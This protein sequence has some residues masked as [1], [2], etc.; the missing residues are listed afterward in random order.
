MKSFVFS[1]KAALLMLVCFGMSG[2]ASAEDYLNGQLIVTP[3]PQPT[4]R[5]SSRYGTEGTT[6]GYV[7]YRF[8]INN[9][10]SQQRRV[11]F[12]FGGGRSGYGGGVALSNA[13]TTVVVEP[14]S[15]TTAT[16]LQPPV[17]FSYFSSALEIRIDNGQTMTMS[18][19]STQHV[20]QR[21]YSSSSSVC[22]ILVSNKITANQRELLTRGTLEEDNSAETPEASGGM[23]MGMMVVPGRSPVET[24]NIWQSEI[25]TDQW[26]DQWLGYTRFDCVVLNNDD[27]QVLKSDAFR[28]LQRYVEMGGMLVV[29][30]ARSSP[31]PNWPKHWVDA[32][33][34]LP[35]GMTRYRALQG[36]AYV[37][38]SGN[39]EESGIKRLREVITSVAVRFDGI[40][41]YADNTAESFEHNVPLDISYVIPVRSLVVLV[42]FFALLIGPVNMVTLGFF[43]RRVWLIWTIPLTSVVA[44]CLVLGLVVFSEGI[45]R[46]TSVKSVTILDQRRR[47]AMT[48]GIVG[49]Y[50]TFAPPGGLTFSNTTEVTP[51]IGNMDGLSLGL[52]TSG[53]QHLTQNWIRPRIPAFF[54]VRKAEASSVRLTFD[55][56]AEPPTVTNGLGVKITDLKVVSPDGKTYTVDLLEAG[57]KVNLKPTSDPTVNTEH[58]LFEV[59][60]TF[61]T[62]LNRN[63]LPAPGRGT[64]TANIEGV[65]PFLEPGIDNMKSFTQA[66]TI[67][68][69]FSGE[70]MPEQ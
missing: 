20:S 30:D 53:S 5:T 38:P 46:V 40:M 69:I 15:E 44:S 3:L 14:K 6:H 8:H 35:A 24:H 32:A 18:Y 2:L 13:S 19:A 70:G 50:R 21:H 60:A 29:L 61:D 47:E 7:E 42:V 66:N 28:A 22:N 48:S 49:Y 36:N 34:S 10:S 23:G 31:L 57:Q 25:P 64:Y 41:R 68:G 39:S 55:W 16:I 12:S 43:K 4:T 26:S 17:G 65:T 45:K 9:K 67:F 11:T 37:M 27:M 56:R 52:Q 54:L 58:T 1:A 63:S 59:N 62:R 33:E 51:V